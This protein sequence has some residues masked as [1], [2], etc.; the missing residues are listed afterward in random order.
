M[1]VF[2]AS[3]GLT[4]AAVLVSLALSNWAARQVQRASATLIESQRGLIAALEAELTSTR[5]L[6]S[7]L[8]E[9]AAAEQAAGES[10]EGLRSEYEQRVVRS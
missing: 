9:A 6:V 4:L 10:L 2:L 7:A 5:A 1:S 8:E 3:F